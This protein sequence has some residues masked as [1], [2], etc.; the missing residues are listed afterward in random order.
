MG[1]SGRSGASQPFW[2][3]GVTFS[4]QEWGCLVGPE[5][6]LSGR[7][8][9]HMCLP[10]H[11]STPSTRAY[12][13]PSTEEPFALS[14]QESRELGRE[15]DSAHPVWRLSCPTRLLQERGRTRW[16]CPHCCLPPPLPPPSPAQWQHRVGPAPA[17]TQRVSALVLHGHPVARSSFLA[18]CPAPPWAQHMQAWP[19]QPPEASGPS[20]ALLP[21]LAGQVLSPHSLVLLPR[22]VT[23]AHTHPPQMVAG[24]C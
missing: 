23:P 11:T 6:Q 9:P 16:P 5:P 13:P 19:S 18:D 21:V 24:W 8:H 14:T 12:T 4:F 3:P 7:E 15:L 22:G 2:S 1:S 10:L 20:L 17:T